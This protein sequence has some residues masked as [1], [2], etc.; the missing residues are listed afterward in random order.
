MVS[1]ALEGAV[2]E[3]DT[4]HPQQ[5]NKS[6]HIRFFKTAKIMTSVQDQIRESQTKHVNLQ[7]REGN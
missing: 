3:V 2:F 6:A 4:P 1:G 5:K 7:R